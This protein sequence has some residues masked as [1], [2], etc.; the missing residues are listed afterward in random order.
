MCSA[1]LEAK[2]SVK[3]APRQEI[4]SQTATV[5]I[6]K[7]T[8]DRVI[9]SACGATN[10]KEY[11]F[12]QRC[13]TKLQRPDEKAPDQTRPL[14]DPTAEIPTGAREPASED[15]KP[16]PQTEGTQECPK[17]SDLIALHA[18]S[19]PACGT[20]V[21]GEHTRVMSAVKPPPRPRL[22]LVLE[23][24]QVGEEYKLG[25][26]TVIGRK[27]GEIAFPHDDLMSGRHALIEKRGDSF[28]LK[29]QG[30]RNGVFV[31][32]KDEVEL[33]PGDMFLIG[34]KLFQFEI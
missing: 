12:C 4:N 7:E 29:D 34:K 25:A 21:G 17:C 27:A 1:P 33:Q 3:I 26:N 5:V 6:S 20:A 19:C 9:C 11:Q 24:S 28:I 32:I 30:S 10:E 22:L 14:R 13:G 18:D 15:A 8:G 23:N 2:D 31:R 16:A